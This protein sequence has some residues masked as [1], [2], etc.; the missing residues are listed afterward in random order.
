MSGDM[1][2]RREREETPVERTRFVQEREM[3]SGDMQTRR[4]REE[5]PV[6]FPPAPPEVIRLL[7]CVIFLGNVEIS[8]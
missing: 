2:T 3:M 6:V 8:V 7:P 1:Q 4:E 5:T